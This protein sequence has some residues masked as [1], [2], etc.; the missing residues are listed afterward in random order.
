MP[1][2]YGLNPYAGAIASIESGGDYGAHGPITRTGDRAY[3]KYQ[4]MGSNVGPWTREVLGQE[5]TPT[6]F[7]ANPQAQE[8]VFRAKFGQYLTKHGPEGAARA[9]FAG[10]RGMNDPTRRD[11]LGTSVADYANKFNR[12]L[13]GGLLGA[14]IG[15]PT[16]PTPGLLGNL[17]S[18]L[19]TGSNPMMQAAQFFQPQQSI[20]MTLPMPPPRRPIDLS[21][22][23]AMFSQPQPPS[24]VF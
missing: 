1:S 20:P 7:L 13:D 9:W 15:Q 4:V 5:L 23:Q 10:E 19:P 24:W 6:Q 16:T 2:H 14:Q 21:R 3:G 8:A 18:G 17:T 12:A 22:L 11:I